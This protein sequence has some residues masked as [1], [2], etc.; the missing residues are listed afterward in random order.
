MVSLMTSGGVAQDMGKKNNILRRK[1]RRILTQ[2]VS[3]TRDWYGYDL[4]IDYHLWLLH[5]PKNTQTI[6]KKNSSK[7]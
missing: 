5:L 1:N 2:L 7:T 3:L 4:T 6:N